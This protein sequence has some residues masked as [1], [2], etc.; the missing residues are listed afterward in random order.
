MSFYSATLSVKKLD[1]A[2]SEVVW[3]ARLY[4][5]DTGNFPAEN[6]SDAAAVD[7]MR[8]FFREGLEALKAKVN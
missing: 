8:T 6:R 3:I 5:A 1:E 2:R 7:A 4:R